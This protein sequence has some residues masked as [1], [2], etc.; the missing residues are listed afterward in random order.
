MPNTPPTP[1]PAAHL[2][3]VPQPVAQQVT[4]PLPLHLGGAHQPGGGHFG[5]AWGYPLL[6][7]APP[8]PPAPSDKGPWAAI[9]SFIGPALTI[10]A[11]V[12]GAGAA[13]EK[14]KSLEEH[15]KADAEV[16][17]QRVRLED[18]RYGKLSSAFDAL[19]GRVEAQTEEL[20]RVRWQRRGAGAGSG[21]PR[22]AT[23]RVD[24]RP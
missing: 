22:D 3:A 18:D 5:G 12:F 6:P 7:P 19:A 8:P 9:K 16:Q 11:I 17:A 24:E 20:K 23:P 10:G 15:R 2:G 14:L 13:N 21:R 4:A 1:A